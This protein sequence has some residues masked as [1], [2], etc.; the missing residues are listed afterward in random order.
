MVTSLQRTN[1]TKHDTTAGFSLQCFISS[2]PR[3]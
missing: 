3:R 1:K 2:L